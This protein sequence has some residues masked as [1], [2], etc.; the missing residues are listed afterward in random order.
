[1][2][3]GCSLFL[4]P[5]ANRVEDPEYTTT[6]LDDLDGL[7]DS[8]E[9]SPK[10]ADIVS[11]SKDSASARN[12]SPED[13]HLFNFGGLKATAM[14]YNN[15]TGP[16]GRISLLVRDWSI[17][18]S[19]TPVDF[20]ILK[21]RWEVG[22]GGDRYYLNNDASVSSYHHPT[23]EGVG[24]WWYQYD[25]FSVADD[26][27]Y[28]YSRVIYYFGSPSDSISS[29]DYGCEIIEVWEFPDR[30]EV[31]NIHLTFWPETYDFPYSYNQ[32]LAITNTT[33]GLEE[34]SM[35][36]R[37]WTDNIDFDIP[38]TFLDYE[39]LGYI[40]YTMPTVIEFQAEKEE[41]SVYTDYTGDEP[42]ITDVVIPFTGSEIPDNY[43][44]YSSLQQ[45]HNRAL[46]M[47]QIKEMYEA[48]NADE[49]KPYFGF[50]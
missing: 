11:V 20:G 15:I 18:D 39:W 34:T 36:T 16:E 47:D 12:I 10:V 21:K 37:A 13:Q 38:F 50:F 27:E 49:D 7:G 25:A 22:G 17:D 2:I 5:A 31:S 41:L 33:S 48:I 42:W 1:M 35:L 44:S 3:L 23:E 30:K 6:L 4:P 43:P 24:L 9:S 32:F 29:G 28:E 46:R 40:D 45:L 26:A 19:Y 8:I 14:N